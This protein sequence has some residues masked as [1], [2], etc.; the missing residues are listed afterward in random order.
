MMKN[1]VAFRIALLTGAI[2][3]SSILVCGGQGRDSTWITASSGCKVYNP[4]PVRNESITWTGEC[5]DGYASGVG[6]LT[7]FKNKKAADYYTGMLKR[8][9][10]QGKGKYTF[11][12]EFRSVKGDGFLNSFWDIFTGDEITE[13]EYVNGDVH[14]DGILI[15]KDSNDSIRYVYKGAFDDGWQE[16][17][18]T[19]IYKD[20]SG[21]TVYQ[22]EGYFIRG[23]KSGKGMITS[24]VGNT[25]WKLHGQFEKGNAE[26][27]LKL[28][29]ADTTRVTYS[30]SGATK[31]GKREGPGQEIFGQVTF[32]GLWKSN[33][34]DGPGKLSLD[35]M[36]MYEGGWK[37]NQYHG[38]GKRQYLNGWKYRGSYKDGF[39]H[40]F[41]VHQWSDSVMYIGEFHKDLFHGIGYVLR[42][43]KVELA[44]WW[45][46]GQLS[47]PQKF[48]DVISL[49]RKKYNLKIAE[50]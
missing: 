12:K 37:G 20:E 33:K 41:G 30:Y 10:P 42:H 3:I 5:P 15:H 32:T 43:G 2:T 48:Q 22:Y 14:G 36:T 31:G 50:H 4:N 28:V 8:G 47:T 27:L 19:E 13:G 9:I 21:D 25:I 45:E 29:A 23:E 34:K 11:V 46:N 17:Y 24:R 39:R 38:E 16:G 1:F 7:W 40:G 18:G 49:L 26:G 6:T 35:T 44:G